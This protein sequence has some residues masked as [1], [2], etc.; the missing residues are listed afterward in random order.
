MKPRTPLNELRIFVAVAERCSFVDAARDLNSSP[1]VV[2]RTIAALEER[3]GVRLL[4]RSTR[5]VF[6][7]P[8]GETYL[9]RCRDILGRLD[10]ADAE[11]GASVEPRGEL[12]LSAPIS[13]GRRQIAPICAEFRKLYPEV[14]IRLTLTDQSNDLMATGADLALRVGLPR[15][16]DFVTRR[17]LRARRAICASP[18][19][20]QHHGE[21]KNP[22]DLERHDGIV[23]C[24]DNEP[25]DRWMF[26]VDGRMESF[27]IPVALSSNSGEVVEQW[28]LDGAGIALKSLWDVEQ[29]L[30]GGQLVECLRDYSREDADMFL[31]Y[32]ERRGLPSRVRAFIDFLDERL[33]Q[34]E[35]RFA[36]L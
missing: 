17:V 6:V 2:T 13:F 25:I 4:T 9:E 14:S 23:I 12:R 24:R 16:G 27:R 26:E 7:T 36:R 15:E 10:A 19:Y 33:Q 18:S 30:E 1:S 34:L 22:A 8:E 5:T 3:L 29:F 28:A 31:I 20:F 32:P 11:V 35:G 21:P